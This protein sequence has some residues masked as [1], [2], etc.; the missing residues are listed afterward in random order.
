MASLYIYQC[1]KCHKL[2][3]ILFYNE[4][5]NTN[6]QF[7]YAKRKCFKLWDGMTDDHIQC[8]CGE[9]INIDMVIESLTNKVGV[10]EP[11]PFVN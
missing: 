5:E 7:A 8:E 10:T 11:Y 3:Q 4:N 9:V 1:R 2:H 6:A